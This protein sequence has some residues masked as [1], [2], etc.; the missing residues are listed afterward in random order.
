MGPYLSEGMRVLE[1]GPGMGFF[2][3]PMARMVGDKGKIYCVDIQQRMLYA[4]RRR[5]RKS[6]L[7][8]RIED[9][10]CSN[11]SL[12]ISDLSGT[13]DL[14]V[15]IAV[16]HEVPDSRML[17]REI[18]STLNKKGKVLVTEPR[19][20]VSAE[21]FSATLSVA[22]ETGLVLSSTPKIRGF[23]SALLAVKSE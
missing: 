3:L 22:A 1:I 12:G 2:T 17:F 4:L 5:A 10:L 13:I 9:R 20:W 8:G 21:N 15:A 6:G 19:H 18:R 7:W 23:R 11:I 14:A 16:V